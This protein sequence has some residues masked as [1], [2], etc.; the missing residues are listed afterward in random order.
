M[1]IYLFDCKTCNE[2][3]EMLVKVGTQEVS[4]TCGV[5]AKKNYAGSMMFSSTGLPNGHSSIRG[6]LRKG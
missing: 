6:T 2:S 4:C 5:M 3:F 1:P